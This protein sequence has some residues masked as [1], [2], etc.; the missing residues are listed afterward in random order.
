MLRVPVLSPTLTEQLYGTA[1]GTVPAKVGCWRGGFLV[2]IL[3]Q[4]RGWGSWQVGTIGTF[5][6][7]SAGLVLKQVSLGMPDET[8]PQR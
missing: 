8:P 2:L 4:I 7:S 5:L 1:M 3:E 6:T